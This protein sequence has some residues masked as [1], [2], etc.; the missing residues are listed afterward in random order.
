MERAFRLALGRS[1]KEE[2]KNMFLSYLD[3]Q[4]KDLDKDD[5]AAKQ[6]AGDRELAVWT[7]ACSVLLNLDETITRP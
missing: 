3:Q 7:L 2:E 1:P 5:E 4:G 6:I